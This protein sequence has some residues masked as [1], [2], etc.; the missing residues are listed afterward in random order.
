M[1]EYLKNIIPR[2]KQY[3]KELDKTENFVDKNWIYIDEDQNRHEYIFLRDKRLIMTLNSTTKEGSWELLPTG[4]LLIK[5][6]TSEYIKLSNLFIQDALMVLKYSAT[7]DTPF[8]LIN[9][10]LIPD[11]N[12]LAY[13]EKF[14]QQKELSETPPQEQKFKILETGELSGPP[15]YDGKIIKIEDDSILSGTYKLFIDKN[16]YEKYV[17]IFENRITRVFF[18]IPY[19]YK[20]S[21]IIIEQSEFNYLSKGDKVIN[22]KSLDIP[23]SKLFPIENFS[24]EKF[25]IKVNADY[26]IKTIY[27]SQLVFILQ[28]SII[29]II[30]LI[31]FALSYSQ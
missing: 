21:K 17:V 27:D 20:T 18:N 30:L 13:L 6:N 28:L 23:I 9:Q 29:I 14:Q 26:K 16:N 15:V 25:S 3:S 19:K 12:V 11:L 2:I 4:E 1:I 10:N 22:G 7:S 8:I 31:L 5:R 24:H